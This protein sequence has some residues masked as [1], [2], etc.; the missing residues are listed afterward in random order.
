MLFSVAEAVRFAQS[1]IAAA[2][3]ARNGPL[4]KRAR[5]QGKL[6]KAALARRSQYDA[7]IAKLKT[8]ANDPRVPSAT[9]EGDSA[10]ATKADIEIEDPRRGAAD[11]ST[12]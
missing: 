12:S 6:V 7:A 9:V 8:D 2:G 10:F 11:Q 3:K 4:S 5:A 1:A